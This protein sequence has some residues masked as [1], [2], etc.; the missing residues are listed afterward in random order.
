M[1][2]S[3]STSGADRWFLTGPCSLNFI[4]P[5]DLRRREPAVSAASAIGHRPG[6]TA[7]ELLRDVGED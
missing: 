5:N 3:S 1:E 7:Y 2:S 4:V 6:V